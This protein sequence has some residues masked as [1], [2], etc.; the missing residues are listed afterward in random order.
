MLSKPFSYVGAHHYCVEPT[1]QRT[2]R[3]CAEGVINCTSKGWT[4][5]EASAV[6][7]MKWIL[8]FGALVARLLEFGADLLTKTHQHCSYVQ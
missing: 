5:G 8:T 4:E 3:W 7:L 1:W 6:R 2:Q